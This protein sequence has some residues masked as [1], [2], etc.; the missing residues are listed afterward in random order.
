MDGQAYYTM[1]P[2]REEKRVRDR[3]WLKTNLMVDKTTKIAAVRW[4]AS[5]VRRRYIEESRGKQR[6]KVHNWQVNSTLPLSGIALLSTPI[7]VFTS[8]SLLVIVGIGF[9]SANYLTLARTPMQSAFK[10]KQSGFWN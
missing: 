2:Q 3:N 9:V 1:Q 8:C 4:C 7:P 5:V 10:C 6:S